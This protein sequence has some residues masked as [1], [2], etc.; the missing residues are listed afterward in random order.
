MLFVC[1]G[2][3]LP[4][5]SVLLPADCL[6]LLLLLSRGG[7][8]GA[9]IIV[10]LR[11]GG[12]GERNGLNSSA[13]TSGSSRLAVAMGSGYIAVAQRPGSM[14]TV[15]EEMRNT[16]SQVGNREHPYDIIFGQ[17]NCSDG[18]RTGSGKI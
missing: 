9:A 2:R 10:G 17:S 7:S 12:G 6:P 11:G 4:A 3:L 8:A 5:V 14:A 1:E 13:S 15:L 18:S 16:S